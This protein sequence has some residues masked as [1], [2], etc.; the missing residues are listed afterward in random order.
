MDSIHILRAG[1]FRSGGRPVTFSEADLSAVAAAYDPTLHEAPIV[2]GHPRHDAPAYGWIGALSADNDGLHA[3]PRQVDAQFAELVRTGRFRKVSAS[4]YGPTHPDNPAPDS[5][6]LRHVG[7]L[8]AMPPVVKGLKQAALAED[9][10]A[11]TVEIA[12]AS[13]AELAESDPQPWVFRT[14]ADLFRSL[15]DRLIETTDVQTADAVLPTPRIDHLIDEAG[16]LASGTEAK[17]AEDAMTKEPTPDDNSAEREATLAEREAAVT[18]REAELAEAATET[19]RREAADFAERLA[20]EGRILPRDQGAI[21]ALLT[22]VPE[23]ATVTFAEGDAAPKPGQ[24]GTFLRQ[25]LAALPVQ[26][27]Y[28]ERAVAKDGAPAKGGG[29]GLPPGWQVAPENADLHNQAV[30]FAEQHNVSYAEAV[31]AVAAH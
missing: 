7:F 6:Y 5:W 11:V 4:L 24:A 23:D 8:G 27:D 22:V 20:D 25:F 9:A 28:A 10:D 19:A 31:S 1:T 15:R 26:V 16:R 17:L 3:A 2:A 12:L 18:G 14:I 29:M 13:G 21:A 30:A